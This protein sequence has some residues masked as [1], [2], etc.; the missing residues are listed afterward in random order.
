[1]EERDGDDVAGFFDDAR[2]HQQSI[3]NRI[4]GDDQEDQLPGQGDGEEAV[5]EVRIVGRRRVGAAGEID[6]KNSGVRTTMPQRPAAAKTKRA[7]SWASRPCYRPTGIGRV[8]HRF[9]A[10]APH[11][12]L[13]A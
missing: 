2:K 11:D 7:S 10:L 3:P 8:R 5:E 6:E 4:G 9:G 1:M 13:L 12:R